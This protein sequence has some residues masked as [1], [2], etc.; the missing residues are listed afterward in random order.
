MQQQMKRAATMTTAVALALFLASAA[1]TTTATKAEAVMLA[2][3][4]QTYTLKNQ[5]MWLYLQGSANYP[6]FKFEVV[7]QPTN[8]IYTL[9]G[10]LSGTGYYTPK[11]GFTG[12]DTFT[13]RIVSYHNSAWHS[14]VATVT[15]AVAEPWAQFTQLGDVTA[16]MSP[17][18]L[19][20]YIKDKQLT[21]ANMP[22]I[23]DVTNIEPYKQTPYGK[24]A[25]AN[26]K[27]A[28]ELA[29]G[30]GAWW[31]LSLGQKQ[32]IMEN[33]IDLLGRAYIWYNFA[34]LSGSPVQ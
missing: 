14:D 24:M 29:N 27:I 33:Y 30:S 6:T 12:V 13:Y 2:S 5:T 9:Q 15:V 22:M 32:W 21:A 23:Y 11:P 31:T 28:V 16:K 17:I 26:A 4:I 1:Y 10:E 3:S 19:A 25:Y 7:K 8:G 34:E 20:Q 18:D